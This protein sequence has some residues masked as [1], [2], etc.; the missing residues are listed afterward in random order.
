[1]SRRK[2]LKLETLRASV[3]KLSR[4]TR[5][6]EMRGAGHP[7]DIPIIQEEYDEAWRALDSQLQRV[8]SER[9]ELVAALR[10][11]LPYI[12][13]DPNDPDGPIAKTVAVIAKFE[14]AA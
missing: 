1:M 7:E 9:A 2:P 12:N 10:N 11:A 8:E 5:A 3:L 13:D 14:A 4:A 6:H